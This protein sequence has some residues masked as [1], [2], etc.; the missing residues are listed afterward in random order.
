M[1]ISVSY[2]RTMAGARQVVVDEGFDTVPRRKRE[3]LIM[4]S[5]RWQAEQE[6]TRQAERAMRDAIERAKVRH[7]LKPQAATGEYASDPRVLISMVAA[8][9]GV[10][11]LDILSSSRRRPVIAAKHDAIAAVFLN[12][13]IDGRRYSMTE[14][15][16]LFGIDHTT[17]FHALQKRGLK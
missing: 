7:S 13:R 3:R 14:I 4:L 15:G 12:C 11:E 2:A 6:A 10:G 5:Q 9:H 16:R 8:W 1:T 17:A